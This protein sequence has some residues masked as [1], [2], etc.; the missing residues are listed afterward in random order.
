MK[1]CV[2]GGFLGS[3][4]T[5]AITTASRML[6]RENVRVAVITNDQGSRLVD[7]AFTNSLDI[8]THEI[9]Q[10]CF[11]CNYKEFHSEISRLAQST[12][13]DLIFAEAV[14]SCADL[15]ATVI[16]PTLDFDA[17]MEITLSVF[18]DGP[19]LLSSMEGRSSFVS[20]DIRYIYKKQLEEASILVV[21]KCDTLSG[22]RI[23]RM[24]LILTAEYPQKIL[25]FQD[26]K[27][28]TSIR[29][30]LDVINENTN[31][32]SPSL[33]ID[34]D[35]YA[36]GEAALAWLDASLT[37]RSKR[38]AIDSS[39]EFIHNM[40]DAVARRQLAI[41]HLKFFLQSGDWGEKISYTSDRLVAEQGLSNGHSADRATV[42]VNARIETDPDRLKQIFFEAISKSQNMDCSIEVQNLDSF[43][44]GYPRPTHRI[45]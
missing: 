20:D 6:L 12:K 27:D 30:W 14:G 11:C 3:G 21:N 10:G 16:N 18:A 40:F 19:V 15:V 25:L 32:I 22:D 26:S 37:V 28:E 24:K 33:E 17:A 2:V 13:P 39:F 44:P 34:Y 4:K 9:R 1:L 35:R 38:K 31:S 41:G 8:P 43:Q 36:Q 42:L 7:T 45:P 23:A 29:K 5:T